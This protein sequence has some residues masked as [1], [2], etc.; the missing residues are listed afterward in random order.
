MNWDDLKIFLAVQ[1]NGSI[2]KAAA[3]IGVSHSTVSR[4]LS[5]LEASIG[6]KLFERHDSGYKLTS[7]AED[8]LE[9]VYGVE[10]SVFALQ[11][12]FEGRDTSPHGKLKITLPNEFALLFMQ[13]FAAFQK[14]YPAIEL[15]FKSSYSLYDLSRREADIAIRVVIKKELPPSLIGRKVMKYHSTSYA[16]RDYLNNH[17]FTA[18]DTN[19]CWLGWGDKGTNQW[20]K[21][22]P[23]PK[24]KIRNRMRN[25]ALMLEGVKAGLGAAYA[26]CFLCD[27]HPDLRRFPD[28][29]PDPAFD[30]WV[31]YHEDL[32]NTVRLRIFMDFLLAAFEKKK[33]LFEG[34][35]Y[36]SAEML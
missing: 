12:K 35:T 16:S 23:Y 33:D 14:D 24:L 32:K 26:P 29:T 5:Q 34:K 9:S 4:R 28:T 27:S 36:N 6:E 30:I 10:D 25:T 15:D 22:T 21:L 31:L 18:A 8:I 7:C 1:R 20:L 13:D 3:S 2:R 11:R 19:A 17:D